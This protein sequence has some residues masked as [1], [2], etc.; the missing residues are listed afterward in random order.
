MVSVMKHCI[1]TIC[2]KANW[3]SFGALFWESLNSGP[4]GFHVPVKS[5]INRV[6]L[7]ALRSSQFTCNNLPWFPSNFLPSSPSSWPTPFSKTSTLPPLAPE[8]QPLNTRSSPVH[9][10]EVT[11]SASLR[12]LLQALIWA[13]IGLI[14]Q[15]HPVH[16]S[17][18]QMHL[19]LR[20]LSQVSDYHM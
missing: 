8:I 15:M 5:Y 12:N 20:F 17:W 13:N 6:L 16:G 1:L 4:S 9:L 10:Q 11:A 2:N 19:N 18:H 14:S 3:S 7:V